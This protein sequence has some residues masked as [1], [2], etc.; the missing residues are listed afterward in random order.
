[1]N[2]IVKTLTGAQFDVEIEPDETLGDFRNKVL[3][4]MQKEEP[5]NMPRQ[6]RNRKDKEITT[7]DFNLVFA[8]KAL[9]D[10]S[11]K[12]SG[13]RMSNGNSLVREG[14][15]FLS[16]KTMQNHS[17]KQRKP[18]NTEPNFEGNVS[19][20]SQNTEKQDTEKN[21]IQRMLGCSIQ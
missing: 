15:V 12:L 8:G 2:I 6:M 11:K 20:I 9:N 19:D 4:K 21:N 18:S 14:V 13:I 1:M 10:N 5:R 3:Q 17:L 7:E 16:F